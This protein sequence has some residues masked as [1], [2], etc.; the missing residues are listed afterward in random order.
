MREAMKTQEDSRQTFWTMTFLG[1]LLVAGI[2]VALGSLELTR[3]N[4]QN[5]QGAVSVPA[6]K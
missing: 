2:L 5:Q 6:T 3:I 4:Q 1:I